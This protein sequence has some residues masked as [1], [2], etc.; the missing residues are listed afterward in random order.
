MGLPE[1]VDG[2]FFAVVADVYVE[3]LP[4]PLSVYA[5]IAETARVGFSIVVLCGYAAAELAS[6]S[7]DPFGGYI[8][9]SS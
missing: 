4:M 7:A 2:C 3:R 1:A 6:G 8:D 9:R 5:A